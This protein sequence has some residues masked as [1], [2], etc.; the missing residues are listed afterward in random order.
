MELHP[1]MADAL[2]PFTPKPDTRQPYTYACDYLRAKVGPHISR[3]EMT[4][5]RNLI[6][7]AL[8]LDDKYIAEKLADQY[9]RLTDGS[10]LAAI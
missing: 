10:L 2:T 5:I 9:H 7:D 1:V 4:Q 3:A 8:G 6:A